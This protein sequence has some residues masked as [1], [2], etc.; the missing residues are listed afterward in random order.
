MNNH[1][2]LPNSLLK[3]SINS[4]IS[5]QIKLIS[6]TSTLNHRQAGRYKTTR[7]RSRG[8]TYEQSFKPCDIG[9]N[10]SFTSFNSANLWEGHRRGDT[11]VEDILIRKTVNGFFPT[12]L[13]SDVVIKRRANTIYLSLLINNQLRPE[14]VYFLVGF[15]EQILSYVLKCPVKLEVQTGYSAR[16]LIVKYI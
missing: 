12:Y 15:T 16:S 5:N 9:V 13:I 14:K 3:C 11:L 8:L 7:D 4:L 6:T 2:K 10:K 1:L